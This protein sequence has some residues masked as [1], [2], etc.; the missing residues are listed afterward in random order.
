MMSEIRRYGFD[1]PGHAQGPQAGDLSLSSGGSLPFLRAA[2]VPAGRDIIYLSGHTPP[3]IDPKAAPDSI[4]AFGDTERQTIGVFNE[5][6]ASLLQLGLSFADLVKIN[7]Y[8]VGDPALGGRMDS[9]G[10]STGYAAFFGTAAQ[11]H[12][13]ARTRAQVVGLVN[14][15]WLVEVEAIAAARPLGAD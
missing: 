15:G 2:A 6:Q 11:P 9:A 13:V 3:V 4:E 5:L 12:L 1:E 8:L 14:P 7:V 10:F